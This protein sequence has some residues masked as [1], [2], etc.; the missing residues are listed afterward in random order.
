MYKDFDVSLPKKEI[1]F[2]GDI[3]SKTIINEAHKYHSNRSIKFLVNCKKFYQ[4]DFIIEFIEEKDSVEQKYIN[5]ICTLLY[6]RSK[7]IIQLLDKEREVLPLEF[8]F[9]NT[10]SK[11]AFDSDKYEKLKV[12]I[13]DKI[14]LLKNIIVEDNGKTNVDHEKE[15]QEKTIEISKLCQIDNSES[16]RDIDYIVKM[17]ESNSITIELLRDVKTLVE[18]RGAKSAVDRIHTALHAYLK[19]VCDSKE[20]SFNK[21]ASITEL[22]KLVNSH[23][24]GLTA[25]KKVKEN[26]DRILK[27]LSSVVDSLNYLR[28]HAS[29]AHANEQMDEDEAQLVIEST[30]TILKYLNNKLYKDNIL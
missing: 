12:Y 18:H 30:L 5:E 23:I 11:I 16:I 10:Y 14:E 27:S 28:N 25:D 13:S 29:L 2:N 21:N 1:G 22:F 3:I 4:V 24:V 8:Q 20:I 17:I 26:I 9:S 7:G 6:N 19:F 15:R